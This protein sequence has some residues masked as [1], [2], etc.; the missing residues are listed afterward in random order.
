MGATVDLPPSG[1]VAKN[2]TSDADRMNH[3]FRRPAPPT[4]AAAPPDD[5]ISFQPQ[6][7]HEEK[8]ATEHAETADSVAEYMKHLLNRT[9][10]GR[11]SAV[12]AEPHVD[13]TV[14][15]SPVAANVELQDTGSD[16]TDVEAVV[17]EAELPQESFAFKFAAAA[18]RR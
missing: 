18:Y 8:K 1:A 3:L 2:R 7:S 9:R 14:H 16:M 13:C 5:A 17:V 15:Q 6:P 12:V 11:S 10:N 4:A